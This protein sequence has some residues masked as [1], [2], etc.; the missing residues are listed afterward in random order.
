[1][2]D[3]A[4]S[5][6]GKAGGAAKPAGTPNGTKATQP[7]N[8]VTGRAGQPP[9]GAPSSPPPV[10]AAAV[11][12]VTQGAQLKGN[13]AL[14][15]SAN[16]GAP[17]GKPLPSVPS[18][19][20][21][22]P[23]AAGGPGARGAA[24]G[25]GDRRPHGEA[26]SAGASGK[27]AD[28]GVKVKQV[29]QAANE[30]NQALQQVGADEAREAVADSQK[31]LAQGILDGV[32]KGLTGHANDG[33]RNLHDTRERLE[34]LHDK[35]LSGA[36]TAE[37]ARQGLNETMRGYGAEAQRVNAG[38]VQALEVGASAVEAT[39]NA[40]ET[41]ATMTATTLAGPVGGTVV[42]TFVRDLNKAAYELSAEAHDVPAPR[43]SLMRYGVDV[44]RG[45]KLDDQT[46]QQVLQ[47]FG[48]SV[49]SSAVDAAVGRYSTSRTAGLMQSGTGAMRSAAVAQTEAQLLFRG[50]RA[51]G[52][53]ALEAAQDPDMTLRQKAE[54]VG[55]AALS[56][57]VSLPFTYLGAGLGI[58]LDS[59]QTL[60]SAGRQML[61]DAVT[62]LA[63]QATST[64]LLEGRGLK[65]SEV[66]GTLTGSAVGGLNNFSQH[67]RTGP[68][69]AAGAD[70]HQQ[71]LTHQSHQSRQSHLPDLTGIDPQRQ[72][73]HIVDAMDSAIARHDQTGD[74]SDLNAVLGWANAGA[75]SRKQWDRSHLQ[76]YV[77]LGAEINRRIANP[78]APAGQATPPAAD[79]APGVGG[80]SATPSSVVRAERELQQ[81]ERLQPVRAEIDRTGQAN[82]AAPDAHTE[83]ASRTQHAPHT[84]Q[85]P[86]QPPAP[87]TSTAANHDPLLDIVRGQLAA[88]ELR[89]LSADPGDLQLDAY[90]QLRRVG[91]PISLDPTARAH[92]DAVGLHMALDRQDPSLKSNTNPAEAYPRLEREIQERHRAID[93]AI[94]RLT[95]GERAN[96]NDLQTQPDDYPA[97]HAGVSQTI[98]RLD[99]A[100][101]QLF[102]K[103]RM[104]SEGE[105]QPRRG[106]LEGQ[107]LHLQEK[108]RDL[109]RIGGESV[110][111]LPSNAL[112]PHATQGAWMAA[113]QRI[114][115]GTALIQLISFKGDFSASDAGALF[116]WVEQGMRVEDANAS[117]SG[118]VFAPHPG[119][120]ADL[121]ASKIDAAL[122]RYFE[123]RRGAA[124]QPGQDRLIPLTMQVAGIPV[125]LNP[126]PSPI[127]LAERQ[128][129]Q[130]AW[131][132]GTAAGWIVDQTLS[133]VRAL[134][135]D[136]RFKETL[137][138][139]EHALP[140]D[141]PLFKIKNHATANPLV[142]A[143]LW[144]GANEIDYK[145]L[146][147]AILKERPDLSEN[148]RV[149]LTNAIATLSSPDV[150]TR[151]L[152]QALE[153]WI[154]LDPNANEQSHLIVGRNSLR[155][156]LLWVKQ[157]ELVEHV[158]SVN[159][160]KE[161]ATG[162]DSFHR[163]WDSLSDDQK[164]VLSRWSANCKEAQS[165]RYTAHQK[166]A[167]TL[168]EL[169]GAPASQPFTAF[170]FLAR[171]RYLAPPES[172]P[173]DPLSRTGRDLYDRLQ[174]RVRAFDRTQTRIHKIE[175]AQ[176]KLERSLD[177]L[178]TQIS[179]SNAALQ[180]IHALR[181]PLAETD[182]SAQIRAVTGPTR[183]PT[184]IQKAAGLLHDGWTHLAAGA[185]QVRSALTGQP[186]REQVL[187]RIELVHDA[188]ASTVRKLE[189]AQAALQRQIEGKQR[190]LQR[191][192][193]AIAK[194]DAMYQQA[195]E[196]NGSPVE[197]ARLRDRRVEQVKR[198]D[199]IDK[200]K[201]KD[202]VAVSELTS[203]SKKL[204][205]STAE[206]RSD[207]L[208]YRNEAK[209]GSFDGEGARGQFV[210]DHAE[211]IDRLE[212]VLRTYVDNS[213][214]DYEK[215]L[216]DYVKAGGTVDASTEPPTPEALAAPSAAGATSPGVPV[217]RSRSSASLPLHVDTIAPVPRNQQLSIAKNSPLRGFISTLKNYHNAIEKQVRESATAMN[218][219]PISQAKHALLRETEFVAAVGVALEGRPSNVAAALTFAKSEAERR[220]AVL[221]QT[222]ANLEKS[223]NLRAVVRHLRE[224]ERMTERVRQV[225]EEAI[226]VADKEAK[227]LAVGIASA[228]D[229]GSSAQRAKLSRQLD[230]LRTA[231]DIVNLMASKVT[232]DAW[233]RAH[234]SE[235]HVH[236]GKAGQMAQ[237]YA[238]ALQLARMTP[239]KLLRAAREIGVPTFAVASTVAAVLH[240]AGR[241]Q[242]QSTVS[243]RIV[244]AESYTIGWDQGLKLTRRDPSFPD[245][246]SFFIQP[247]P[248]QALA[249]SAFA[250]VTPYVQIAQICNVMGMKGPLFGGTPNIQTFLKGSE[251]NVTS[252]D[253]LSGANCM[254]GFNLGTYKAGW[255]QSFELSGL[256]LSLHEGRLRLDW[257]KQINR[258]QTVLTGYPISLS[259]STFI[260]L[261][262]TRIAQLFRQDRAVGPQISNVNGYFSGSFADTLRKLQRGS[263]FDV[264]TNNPGAATGMQSPV[265]TDWPNPDTM[266]DP[267]AWPG[268]HVLT[269]VTGVPSVIAS[270]YADLVKNVGAG[271]VAAAGLGIY[272]VGLLNTLRGDRKKKEA[273]VDDAKKY[274]PPPD[275]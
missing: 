215:A 73:Q 256:Y 88:P 103:S 180:A 148:Q 202:E 22:S 47:S 39:R 274:L 145:P 254:I 78:A 77:R 172:I 62:G 189:R 51:V 72:G 171:N 253:S 213:N 86:A 197:V 191:A 270:G 164:T 186:P 223:T 36:I 249:Q 71:H 177:F 38:R 24:G 147:R 91:A 267:T 35:V 101:W 41:T 97:L 109:A 271:G 217:D 108:W 58:G 55:Q 175:Q 96:P 33:Q 210:H 44:V 216:R 251:L 92:A 124:E 235:V 198:R 247:K 31:N 181:D 259:N 240:G 218:V 174:E 6:R 135:L 237:V 95:R 188:L 266:F 239:D 159:G 243:G 102:E 105:V 7:T 21:A 59:G 252:K 64:W 155:S 211:P 196:R 264:Y 170:V 117:L 185:T 9:K 80:L 70:S 133:P 49:V 236:V 100:R 28:P 275:G 190:D 8:A 166:A 29:A 195:V 183:H 199:D 129:R 229:S 245:I 228:R 111:A 107:T 37:Q 30:I 13:V 56:Q 61:G 162:N 265:P 68:A 269:A 10:G 4:I 67:P 57:V 122:P 142:L 144:Y 184:P 84:A 219:A 222:V 116:R 178:R 93:S 244:S 258:L 69:A 169:A 226:A 52:Q 113:R 60:T 127:R 14:G 106:W 65:G 34:Q 248:N 152:H 225:K 203:L 126:N 156:A 27:P 194:T 120:T 234:G 20:S 128:A 209:A 149:S 125:V 238:N 261:G 53:A 233:T 207:V 74:S 130:V 94:A 173:Y 18:R 134:G 160:N 25:T 179:Q 151:V 246:A 75:G 255:G 137:T 2:A 98:G 232:G 150:E 153:L 241:V 146:A 257:A 167:I 221:R 110:P 32:R 90:E 139:I 212:S 208:R 168:V 43:Q 104:P 227:R 85:P 11:K 115:A 201:L 112:L 87:E 141:H 82:S 23:A 205:E 143:Q 16:P 158:N 263:G 220:S 140:T 161:S 273:L 81:R 187:E 63:D 50:S 206:I 192:R 193:K 268:A 1:M 214:A 3:K 242:W 230:E 40:A 121:L 17:G 79:G 165:L 123:G 119:L 200:A 83:P 250:V 48:Q 12:A 224:V 163:L 19:P 260:N 231:R 136:G 5:D 114:D 118:T 66:A 154:E 89:Q 272:G 182:H 54:H 176:L 45:Q 15:G 204:R 99:A 42:G 26:T 131:S 132:L 262:G 138:P 46:R 76:D 157:N